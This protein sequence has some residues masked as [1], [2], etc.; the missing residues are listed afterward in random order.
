MKIFGLLLLLF[1]GSNA[2]S[3]DMQLPPVDPNFCIN[4]TELCSRIE[5]YNNNK[6]PKFKFNDNSQS[7][8]EQRTLF[9]MLNTL[10]AYSTHLAVKNNIGK[11]VN[12]LLPKY[13][14]P[15]DIVLHKITLITLYD[16]LRM[17]DNELILRTMNIG[18]IYVIDNNTQILDKEGII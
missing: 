8:K 4:N 13:P 12:P 9:F 2:Y 11:E 1:L 17:L 7:L 10:D 18:L 14:K 16:Y 3:Y 6:L 5:N 15:H